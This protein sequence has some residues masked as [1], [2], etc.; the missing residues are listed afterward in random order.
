MTATWK[1]ANVFA[2]PALLTLLGLAL[3]L[4]PSRLEVSEVEAR[5]LAPWPTLTF[6]GLEDGSYT[7]DVEMFI[8]DHFP[9]RERFVQFTF[10]VRARWG[11]HGDTSFYASKGGALG[12]LEQHDDWGKEREVQLP[13]A[14]VSAEDLSLF[15]DDAED[16]GDPAGEP[17]AGPDEALLEEALAE[18]PDAGVG[19]GASTVR[20]GVLIHGGRG[21][22]LLSGSDD[23]VR[24][25][26]DVVNLYAAAFKNQRVYSL[27]VPGAGT[28]YLPESQKSR[29][30]DEVQNL[31]AMRARL[32]P[33]VVWVDVREEL[34]QHTAEEIY[35]RTDHHWTG[36]GAYYGYRAFCTA[37]GLDPTPQS[38]LAWKVRPLPTLGSLYRMT[39]DRGL[40]DAPDLTRY[41]QPTVPYR[42]VTYGGAAYDQPVRSTFIDE[43]ASGYLVYM[44]GDSALMAAKTELKNGRRA[45]LV[46][47]SFGNPLGPLLLPHFEQVIVVDYR[48]FRGTIA[49]LVR[50]FKVTDVIVQNSTLT[51]NDPYHRGRLRMVLFTP[52]RSSRQ[53]DGGTR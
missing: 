15:A 16:A 40:R 33:S 8:A 23:T 3:V 29:S 45:L 25:F 30:V 32:S 34:A 49:S 18:E 42:S 47:N 35:Y 19:E 39:H 17:D 31:S 21:M 2:V 10:E 24:G 46:K 51:A 11:V 38:E 1:T 52:M 28:F 5:T 50:R 7:R 14:S 12:G 41:F 6:D 44:G 13:D 27:M 26:A 36:L 48:F 43:R 9:F 20:D 4:R 53:A 37:A 22:M